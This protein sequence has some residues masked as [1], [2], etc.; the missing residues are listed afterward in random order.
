MSE[1]AGPVVC[2]KRHFVII[3]IIILLILLVPIPGHFDDGG[4]VA[5]YAIIYT[6]HNYRSL[7][8]EDGYHGVIVG[9]RV[10]VFGVT[11]FDNTRFERIG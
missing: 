5:Y 11:V 2:R 9:I 8:E 7:W 4:T 6:V 10:R 1:R 3:G